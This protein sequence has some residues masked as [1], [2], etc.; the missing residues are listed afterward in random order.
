MLKDHNHPQAIMVNKMLLFTVAK[1]AHLTIDLLLGL[2]VAAFYRG[3]TVV[4]L[5]GNKQKN[6]KNIY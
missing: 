1:D 6:D 3:H 4:H 5:W 2:F